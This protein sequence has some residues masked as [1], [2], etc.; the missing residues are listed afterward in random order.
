MKNYVQFIL[1][2]IIMLTVISGGVFYTFYNKIFAPNVVTDYKLHINTDATFDEVVATLTENHV[3]QNINGFKWTAEKMNYPANVRSGL[4][5][6]EG[7]QSNRDI[8][9]KLRGGL[10]TPVKVVLNNV[11][12]KTDLAGK[13]SKQLE[14]DSVDLMQ[15][16]SDESALEKMGVNQHNVMCRFI[17]NTYEFY[18]NISLENYVNRMFKEYDAFWTDLRK[19]QAKD[20]GLTPN[21]AIVLAS[22]VEK[23]YKMADERS[24]IARVYINRLDKG[25]LLQADPTVKYAVG[26]LSIKRVLNVHTQVDNPY[27]TYKY[28][29]LPPG[30]ICLPETTTI[31]A[32]LQAPNHNYIYFC[33]KPD[34]SGYHSFNTTLTGHLKDANLYWQALNKLGIK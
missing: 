12:F 27:N 10:Q 29:G 19:K 5:L 8:L 28:A 17:P 26:D 25:M 22:I 11:N 23:E 31:D 2:G 13:I 6:L 16:L 33:A 9:V 15:V 1:V 4:Y 34:L 20:L 30:P 7:G 21:D 32:V 24:K 18:W 14:I 3:L